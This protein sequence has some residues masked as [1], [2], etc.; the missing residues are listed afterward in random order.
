MIEAILAGK[1]RAGV[2]GKMLL[3]GPSIDPCW[4][5]QGQSFLP[6]AVDA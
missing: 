3:V 1:Q 2:T 5:K 4:K 6:M